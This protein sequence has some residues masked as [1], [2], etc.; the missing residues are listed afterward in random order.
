MEHKIEQQK[1]I[2][3][4]DTPSFSVS[5]KKKKSESENKNYGKWNYKLNFNLFATFPFPLFFF[6]SVKCCKKQKKSNNSKKKK[7]INLCCLFIHFSFCLPFFFCRKPF[8]GILQSVIYCFR[9]SSLKK[10]KKKKDVKHQ[11]QQL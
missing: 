2:A 6:F 10:L 8:T 5:D 7:Q 11:W 9:Y 4:S 1:S 3:F